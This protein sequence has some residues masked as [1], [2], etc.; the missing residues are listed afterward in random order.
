MTATQITIKQHNINMN[1]ASDFT[2]ILA[3]IKTPAGLRD[4]KK[5]LDIMS[6]T[7][8]SIFFSIKEKKTRSN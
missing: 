7:I 8:P 6:G 3:L 2:L 1:E 5:V 4:Y